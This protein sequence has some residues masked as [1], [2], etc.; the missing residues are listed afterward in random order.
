MISLVET[1]V[2][3]KNNLK[4]DGYVSFSRNR[5]NGNMG[6]IATLVKE[7][8]SGH[9][10]KTSAG[11]ND[12]EFLVVRLSQFHVPINVI[13]IYG[14]QESRS[15]VDDIERRWEE[16]VTETQKIRDRN[17]ELIIACD[18]NSHVGDLVAGNHTKVSTGGQLIRDF[19]LSDEY[20][21]VNSS[22][23]CTG[24]PFTRYDPSNPLSDDHKSLLDLIVISKNLEKY[25][26]DMTIDKSLVI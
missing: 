20:V 25:L 7:S 24:G 4:L 19:L 6:G 16:I 17:E 26:V 9:A 3:G 13:T 15:R 23:K 8:E 18:A 5:G 22:S 14:Q 21:L 1:N 11:S 10:L 12:N 2:K